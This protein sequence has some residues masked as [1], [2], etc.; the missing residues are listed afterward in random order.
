[1]TLEDVQ[2]RRDTRGLSLDE[3]GISGLRYPVVVCD[4]G[5]AKQQTV[6]EAT[7]SVTLPAEAKGAHL[8]RFV[9]VMHEHAT[10]ISANTLP[11]IVAA[12]RQRLAA[13][14]AR[15]QVKATY[16]RER[17]APVTD[18]PSIMGY[19]AVWSA[20]SDGP[21]GHL[22]ISTRVPVTSV[23][24]CSRAI[25]DYGAHNQRGHITVHARLRPGAAEPL[26]VED[27]IDLAER[28]A[29]APVYPLVK[30]PDER[31]VTMLAFD[32]PV[33]VE[34]M[35]RNVAHELRD[36]PRVSAFSVHAAND[37]SIHDHIAYATL[38]WP[39]AGQLPSLRW[40]LR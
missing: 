8:S 21:A 7:M 28:S 38:E 32:N 22:E 6:G 18:T 35:A 23:C 34:D 5:G 2:G 29:S 14:R 27:L 19:E 25:S 30:R 1:M 15:V 36:D 13:A 20:E 40:G 10:E 24:P 17:R 31:Y 16:F 11:L 4:R 12:L 26:W 39:R 3:V 33:F 9:E 37:E